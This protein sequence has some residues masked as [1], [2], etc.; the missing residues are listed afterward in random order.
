M[1]SCSAPSRAC[2]PS[3]LSTSSAASGRCSRISPSRG[4]EVLGPRASVLSSSPHLVSRSCLSPLFCSCGP[5]VR[6]IFSSPA[7]LQ[8]VIVSRIVVARSCRNW[9][10]WPAFCVASLLFAKFVGDLQLTTGVGSA[11]GD[12]WHC[13]PLAIIHTFGL[14]KLDAYDIR[15]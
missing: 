3:A 13:W 10:N 1:W 12:F 2:A 6:L 4:P 11:H 14:V 15:S 7:C 8:V 5:H 9:S